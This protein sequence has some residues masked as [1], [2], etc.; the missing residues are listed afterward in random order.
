MANDLLFGSKARTEI[1]LGIKT[2][3]DAVRV[4]LGPRGRNV[5]IEQ[6]FG[7]PLII[8]D[9]VT[10]A[11]NVQ[12]KNKYQN[13]GASL[14]IEAASKTNDYAGDGTTTAVILASECVIKG[15]ELVEKG[16]N[17]VDIKEG[18]DFYL[19]LIIEKIK[20]VAQSIT[21]IDDLRQVATLSSA[22]SNIGNLIADAYL[23]VGADGIVSVEESRGIDTY[24]DIVKGYSYDRGY[25]SSYMANNEE[26]QIA[27]LS[28]PDILVT[29]KKIQSMKE[30]M[31][32]LENAMKV[33]K[34]LLIICDD[35]EQEVLSAIVMNKLRG[36]FNV[37]VTKAPSFGDR[38]IQLL[39]DIACVSGAKFVST[40]K[41]DDLATESLEILGSASKVTVS[42]N[43]TV[44]I[45][46]A[47]DEKLV[48]EYVLGLKNLYDQ[49]DNEYDKEKYRERIAKIVSGIALIK[50]GA[51]TE[52]ELHDKKLRIEDALCA[53]K[54]A[55]QSGIIEGGGKVFYQIAK[56]LEKHQE[57]PDSKSIIINALQAPFYQILDNAGVKIDQETISK[58]LIDEE[59]FDAKTKQFVN[60]KK[61]GIVD[62]ASVEIAAI[63]NAL[64][65]AGIVLTTECAIISNNQDK[66]VDEENLL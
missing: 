4:T 29:D 3:S 9:G 47:G 36:V 21:S 59:W 31:P 39:K 34:P 35:I 6:D 11:K 58:L 52:V 66:N 57:Y 53:T 25:A 55:M 50:V 48:T 38:K 32:Y 54:A 20:S 5:I 56:E 10:I 15:L 45:D 19:P 26:K 51:A 12:L 27:E 2:L 17:P 41:G 30:I 64:S 65:I 28:N 22:N 60:L 62:P 42:Q 8:N 24:L 33:G 7:T 13:L 18:F 63:T 14:I 40:T 49:S 61:V 37:V 43:T 46:G 44:I 23:E 1:A 16:V